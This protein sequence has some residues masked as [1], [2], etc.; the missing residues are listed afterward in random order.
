MIDDLKKDDFSAFIDKRT[1]LI[2]EK[3]VQLTE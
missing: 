3:I 1:K 2:K